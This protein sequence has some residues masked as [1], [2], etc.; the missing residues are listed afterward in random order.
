MNNSKEIIERIKHLLGVSSNIELSKKLGVSYNTLNSWLKRGHIPDK[1]INNIVQSEQVSYDYIMTGRMEEKSKK[2]YL[3]VSL[4]QADAGVGIYNYS[5]KEILLTLN[6][7]IFSEYA[8]KKLIAIEVVGD[9]MEPV[10]RRGDFILI[11]PQYQERRTEDGI[12][13]IRIDGAIKIKALQ[14][15]LDGTIKIISYNPH[16]SPEVYDPSI[17]QID[18]EILGKHCMTIAR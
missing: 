5:Q 15:Q 10:L 17:S 7:E 2:K 3:P 8:K 16:Y 1:Y 12:Y 11:T 14:F 4:Y 18:F 6:T 9:S 13:A